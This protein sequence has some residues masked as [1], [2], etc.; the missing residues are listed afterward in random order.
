MGIVLFTANSS[1]HGS[2]S[3]GYALSVLHF[4]C[5]PSWVMYTVIQN[6][7]KRK[8][9]HDPA[10]PLLGTNPKNPETP[11]WEHRCTPAF[12]AASLTVAKIW[13]QPMCSSVDEWTKKLWYI[14]TVEYYLAIKKGGKKRKEEASTLSWCYLNKNVFPWLQV[15]KFNIFFKS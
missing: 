15:K 8:P 4:I 13:K 7:Q 11:T 5:L 6:K 14:Y 2:W 3:P 9:P 10:I 12:I 1:P